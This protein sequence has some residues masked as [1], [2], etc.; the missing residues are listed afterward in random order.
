MG[1]ATGLELALINVSIMLMTLSSITVI[2]TSGI[3]WTMVLSIMCGILEPSH[4]I[5]LS[6]GIIVVGLV[7]ANLGEGLIGEV[8]VWGF[9]LVLVSV[10]LGSVKSVLVQII[11]QGWSVP[12]ID[13]D[14]DA[15]IIKGNLRSKKLTP[16]ETVIYMAPA[17][18][19]VLIIG[20]FSFEL[21]AFVNSDHPRAHIGAHICHFYRLRHRL[22]NDHRRDDI[23]HENVVFD[24]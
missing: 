8:N 17:A 23:Q 6:V 15:D 13:G 3:M 2:K 18:I 14:D 1:I 20:F 7:L 21:D 19:L 10:L 11:L 4:R 5:L 22:W 24:N 9:L 12:E 16:L